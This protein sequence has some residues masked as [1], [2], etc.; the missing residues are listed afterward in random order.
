MS[1]SWLGGEYTG[2]RLTLAEAETTVTGETMS[3]QQRRVEHVEVSATVTLTGGGEETSSQS[4]GPKLTAAWL[5]ALADDL[6]PRPTV[7]IHH[8]GMTTA[9]GSTCR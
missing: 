5:R 2:R 1:R 4:G 6:D 8:G 7:S 9:P 3:D